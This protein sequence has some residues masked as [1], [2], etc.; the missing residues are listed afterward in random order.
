MSR[1]KIS[2]FAATALALVMA[3]S[4]SSCSSKS[5]PTS[6]GG[7]GNPPP[8][9][10]V[11]ISGSAFNPGTISV[12]AGTTVT[13]TN[14]DNVSLTVT[15]DNGAFTS[16]GTLGNGATYQFMFA[17]AGSYLYHCAIHPSMTGTVTVTP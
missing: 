6:S 8:A 11:D 4:L 10:M 2:F 7:G 17:T 14:K 9:N 13:W 12:K 16:S 3:W 1:Q 5:N 15:S